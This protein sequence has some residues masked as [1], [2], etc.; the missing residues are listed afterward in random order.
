MEHAARSSVAVRA[1]EPP[2]RPEQGW[3]LIL[4]RFAERTSRG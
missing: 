4:G 1:W 3:D 2:S